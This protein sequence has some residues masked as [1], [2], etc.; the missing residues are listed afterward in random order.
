MPVPA[1]SDIRPMSPSSDAVD[2]HDFILLG[3]DHYIVSAYEPRLVYNIPAGC[4][5]N[6]QGAKVVAARLQEV[7]RGKVVFDWLSTDHAELYALSVKLAKVF[8]HLL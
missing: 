3:D 7:K 8:N 6:P 2:G 5:P 4:G 1:P